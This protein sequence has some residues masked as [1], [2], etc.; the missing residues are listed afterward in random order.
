MNLAAHRIPLP[1]QRI[2]RSMI[3][4]WLCFGVY[5]LRGRSGI[6]FY[7][8]IAALQCM[9]PYNR[10]MGK[11]AQ[12]RIVGTL[13]GA[14]WGLTVL[15]LELELLYEGVPDE[16]P[17]CLLLGLFTGVV[18]YSTVLL[19]AREAANFSVVVFLSVGVNHIGDVNPYLFAFRRLFGILVLGRLLGGLHEITAFLRKFVLC[20][21]ELVGGPAKSP[22]ELGNPLRSEDYQNEQ[23]DQYNFSPAQRHLKPPAY[24]C[25]APCLR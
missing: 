19:K 3:A 7:S 9:Q 12:K 1:G 20:L 22:C 6:P 4:V 23:H 18:L 13:I 10:E 15:L 5:F 8:V 25:K 11:V 2:W 14:F 21:L 16:L 24:A 17:H